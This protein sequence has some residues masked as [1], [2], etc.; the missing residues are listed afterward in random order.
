MQISEEKLCE[1]R[2]KIST[3]EFAS[4][5]ASMS[6][7]VK[8]A[9]AGEAPKLL[10]TQFPDEKDRKVIESMLPEMICLRVVAEIM[11][12]DTKDVHEK[13][14]FNPDKFGASAEQV[15]KCVASAKTASDLFDRN[16][17]YLRKA[18]L[19]LVCS[20]GETNDVEAKNVKFSE[21]LNKLFGVN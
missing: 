7:V 9:I 13:Y 17:T 2:G 1:L 12:E 21:L 18:Y 3:P 20:G 19:S 14:G 6:S 5:V 4:L 16:V 10:S 15:L 8:E 11:A